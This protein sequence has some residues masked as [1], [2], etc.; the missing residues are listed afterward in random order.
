MVGFLLA[1]PTRLADFIMT[2]MTGLTKRRLAPPLPAAR[3][4]LELGGR[5]GFP[6]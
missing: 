2:R 6:N 1:L 5:A 3:P 4:S